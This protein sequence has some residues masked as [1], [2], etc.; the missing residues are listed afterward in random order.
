MPTST[1]PLRDNKGEAMESVHQVLISHRF[2]DTS[3]YSA[4]QRQDVK[5]S[6]WVRA[7]WNRCAVARAIAELAVGRALAKLGAQS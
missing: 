4:L 5:V 7:S 3:L 1:R 2:T 6:A